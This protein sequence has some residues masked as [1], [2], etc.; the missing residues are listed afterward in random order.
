MSITAAE[1]KALR[2]RTGAGMME[3]K[4]ALTEA[5]GNL[6]EAITLLRKR[7]LAQAAKK[8]GRATTEGL[9]T[10]LL[11]DNGRRGVLVEVDC[12]TDFVARTDDFQ[13]LVRQVARAVL[14]AGHGATEAWLRDANGPVAALV[15]AAIARI[16]ENITVP[17]AVYFE[18][19][20][21]LGHYIHLGGRIGVLVDLRGGSD[22]ALG[23]DAARTLLKEVAMHVAAASPQYVRRDEVPAAVLERERGIY[24]AQLE[25]Q[26]KPP[27]VV[28]KIVEGKLAAFYEQAVLLDQ[29]SIRDPKVTVGAM[30]AAASA[31]AG[32]PLEVV[33]FAR[34]KVGEAASA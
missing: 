4:A 27:A 7:G 24:R 5:G 18:T 11:E 16:G 31:A 3:C 9:V 13:S 34:F 22:A 17:R 30:V 8:A 19:D 25:G 29:P 23:S 15:A 12:E 1:V 20:G 32:A 33:R 28:E 21:L 14:D 10:A 26:N 6:E 2:D